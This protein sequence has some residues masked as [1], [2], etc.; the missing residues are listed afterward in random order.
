M[1]SSQVFVGNLFV[2]M[3]EGVLW[4]SGNIKGTAAEISLFG[5]LK[6]YLKLYSALL[7]CAMQQC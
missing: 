2:V 1:W 4:M 6:L 3:V 5:F 7:V